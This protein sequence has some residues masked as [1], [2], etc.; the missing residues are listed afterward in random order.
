[1]TNIIDSPILSLNQLTAGN[2]AHY[3]GQYFDASDPENRNNSQVTGNLTYFLNS[4]SIGRHELKGGYEFFRSQRTGG[5]SQ[6]PTGY[7]FDSDYATDASGSARL[8][9]NGF[10]IPVFVPGE[11]LIEN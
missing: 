1:S 9:A 6:S 3:N 5:N 8:D 7:V 2:P 11:S 4:G 10:M